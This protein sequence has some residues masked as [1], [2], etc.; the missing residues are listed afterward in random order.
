MGVFFCCQHEDYESSDITTKGTSQQSQCVY[1][2]LQVGNN[3]RVGRRAL[4]EVK[5]VQNTRIG[6]IISCSGY[7]DQSAS[8]QLMRY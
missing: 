5:A 1:C 8:S 2:Q 4:H 6:C 3:T 7:N